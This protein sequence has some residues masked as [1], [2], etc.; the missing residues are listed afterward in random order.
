MNTVVTVTLKKSL[1]GYKEDQIKTAY[2]LGLKKIGDSRRH[3]W[4]GQTEGKIRKISHL[5]SVEN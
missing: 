3:P 5:V 4:N 2:S 1:I